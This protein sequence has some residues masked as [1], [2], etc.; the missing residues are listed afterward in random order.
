MADTNDEQQLT[1]ST[2]RGRAI[3][4]F[5][6]RDFVVSA[7]RYPSHAGIVLAAQRSWTLLRLIVALDRFL[8]ENRAD[9]VAGKV[10]WL[11]RWG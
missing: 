9:D 7:Q 10:V 2:A 3:F 5:N 6:V 4:T 8:S 1:A 11:N